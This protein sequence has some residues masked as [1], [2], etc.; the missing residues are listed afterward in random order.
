MSIT[1]QLARI[2]CYIEYLNGRTGILWQSLINVFARL[3]GHYLPRHWPSAFPIVWSRTDEISR[4]STVAR[5]MCGCPVQSQWIDNDL[6]MSR[7][8]D[9][10]NE[11]KCLIPAG[12]GRPSGLGKKIKYRPRVRQLA[13]LVERSL[14]SS[15]QHLLEC[16]R[17]GQST[18]SL[19][20]ST[21][22]IKYHKTS[23]TKYD[24][25]FLSF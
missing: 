8:D 14:S 16:W 11:S 1:F 19:S 21:S 24:P 12:H 9:A 13:I 18:V 10:M 2:V 3:A 23:T 7:V 20:S 4:H 5:L 6:L 15:E 25:F 17:H 22:S